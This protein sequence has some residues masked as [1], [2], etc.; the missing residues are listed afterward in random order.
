M[1]N[2]DWPFLGF[3]ALWI[4]GLGLMIA[5]LSYASYLATQQ[6]EHFKQVLKMPACRKL[7]LLG[8]VIFCI[9]LAGGVS[10]IWE[11]IVWAVLAIIFTYQAWQ[12][13]KTT[14]P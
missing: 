12:A 8:L 11:R 10:A 2:V 5:S 13:G 14:N 6:K 4:L 9:G 3:N 7:G 1:T